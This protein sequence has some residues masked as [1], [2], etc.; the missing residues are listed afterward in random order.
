M[1]EIFF[2]NKKHYT[3]TVIPQVTYSV[4]QALKRKSHKPSVLVGDIHSKTLS[5]EKA[6]IAGSSHLNS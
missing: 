1:L 2:S 3:K 4:K 5:E 6:V